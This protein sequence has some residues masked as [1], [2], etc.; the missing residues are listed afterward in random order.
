M[1]SASVC[2]W[3]SYWTTFHWKDGDDDDDD[4][5]VDENEEKKK[6]NSFDSIQF[7]AM[8]LPLVMNNVRS[9][10]NL[11]SSSFIF[12]F[13]I[14][15][16]FYFTFFCPC[17]CITFYRRSKQLQLIGKSVATVNDH[18]VQSINYALYIYCLLSD[19]R[20]ILYSITL[21]GS[22]HSLVFFLFFS[23]FCCFLFSVFLIFFLK[24]P[25]CLLVPKLFVVQS[26]AGMLVWHTIWARVPMFV[27]YSFQ[28]IV[29]AHCTILDE[30]KEFHRRMQITISESGSLVCNTK[31][32]GTTENETIDSTF[33]SHTFSHSACCT[34]MDMQWERLCMCGELMKA[35]T[36]HTEQ[37]Y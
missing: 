16:N 36:E 4:F 9:Y 25:L 1:R 17:L 26:M 8:S 23:F 13:L 14:F 19:K 24:C 32:N 3:M 10:I 11:S 15:S 27:L 28:L 2:V 7:N 35:N 37:V 18:P 31:A 30:G 33:H 20:I 34:N 29:H 5:D 21:S 6:E 12:V 22:L